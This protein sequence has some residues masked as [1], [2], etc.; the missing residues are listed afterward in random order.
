MPLLRQGLTSQVLEGSLAP[1]GG[2][3]SYGYAT[4]VPAP[5]LIYTKIGAAPIRFLTT[6]IQE[7]IGHVQLA[8]M[9]AGAATLAVTAGGKSWRVTTQDE[10]AQ[11]AVSWEPMASG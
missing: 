10:A 6:I 8:E 5:Q 9:S 2:W 1:K 11:W 7:G 4:K 3:V